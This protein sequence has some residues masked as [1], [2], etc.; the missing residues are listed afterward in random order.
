[1]ICAGSDI[2]N[3]PTRDGLRAFVRRMA[4]IEDPNWLSLS[5][6]RKVIEGLKAWRA[7]EIAKKEGA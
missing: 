7:R 5:D 3:N 6:A 2:P 1:V 4:S